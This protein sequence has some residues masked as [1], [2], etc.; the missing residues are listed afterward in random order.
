[1][2]DDDDDSPGNSDVATLT[3]RAQALKADP[4]TCAHGQLV[5]ALVDLL[6]E[7]PGAEDTL[8]LLYQALRVDPDR[9]PL[10]LGVFLGKDPVAS[11]AS[12]R[13]PVPFPPPRPA[14]IRRPPL[15]ATRDHCPTD[16]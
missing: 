1:M 14:V 8:Y 16:D 3:A 15:S 10:L 9:I 6:V 11:L 13:P 5:Q 7:Y 12:H 4:M 2:V